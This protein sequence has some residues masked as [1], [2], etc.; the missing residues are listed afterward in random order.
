MKRNDP[1]ITM[2]QN[3]WKFLMPYTEQDVIEARYEFAGRKIETTEMV[4]LI[5]N[6]LCVT[7]YGKSGIGKTSLLQA[8]VFPVLRCMGFCPMV[9]RFKK[10][11]DASKTIINEIGNHCEVV[12]T[13][14]PSEDVCDDDSLS[15]FFRS[16]TFEIDGN[17][18]IPVIVF[19]QFEEFLSASYEESNKL[20]LEINNLVSDLSS[21]IWEANYR[22][23]ISIREDYLYLLEDVL[24][25]NDFS[26]L[27]ANRIRLGS[28]KPEGI[29]E[30]FNCG[31]GINN[32]KLRDRIIELSSR[33]GR[34][35][36]Y[37]LS[38]M[39]GM[40]YAKTNGEPDID[41]NT[42]KVTGESLIGEYYNMCCKYIS[43]SAREYIENNLQERGERQSVKLSKVRK[44]IREKDLSRLTGKLDD[45]AAKLLNVIRIGDEEYAEFIHD[46]LSQAVFEQRKNRRKRSLKVWV[47]LLVI[48]VSLLSFGIY[49]VDYNSSESQSNVISL[50]KFLNPYVLKGNY[51]NIKDTVSGKAEKLNNRDLVFELS[52]GNYNSIENC[53]NLR[54][55]TIIDDPDYES[56]NNDRKVSIDISK[57]PLLRDIYIEDSL[58]NFSLYLDDAKGFCNI[59]L[60]KNV[61]NFYIKE[62]SNS[63]IN[64]E[65]DKEDGYVL[66]D[67]NLW[68]INKNKLLFVSSY[69]GSGSVDSLRFPSGFVGDSAEYNGSFYK[70]C[71]NNSKHSSRQSSSDKLQNEDSFVY[72]HTAFSI[73]SDP[74]GTLR[75]LSLPSDSVMYLPLHLIGV[76]GTNFIFEGIQLHD[77]LDEWKRIKEIHIPFADPIV[78]DN[79]YGFRFERNVVIRRTIE[80]DDARP[81]KFDIPDSIKMHITLCVP[82]GSKEYYYKIPDYK[83][84]REIREDS[85]FAKIFDSGLWVLKE[86]FGFVLNDNALLW[87]ADF[88]LV[89]VFLCF[90]SLYRDRYKSENPDAGTLKVACLSLI[91]GFTMVVLA[92]V[93][94]IG[95]YWW[96]WKLS[97]GNLWL[98][99]IGAG[100]IALMALIFVYKG[101]FSIYIYRFGDF[102]RKIFRKLTKRLS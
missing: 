36:T 100:L 58:S 40:I 65:F 11:M 89:G 2:G 55:L 8:G 4:S 29:E 81:Y 62:R 93:V 59:H 68:N 10:G 99:N 101:V 27:K 30:I 69:E 63:F 35:E 77:N 41:D 38:L 88:L 1:N 78:C 22:F 14:D 32:R 85:E 18:V 91:N 92:I 50:S 28:L 74:A 102:V 98:S 5:E 57:A 7:L 17:R 52:R 19:D 24:D 25:N 60:G 87:I 3:P 34:V 71:K 9:C 12:R 75:V 70:R 67:E 56:N 79:L 31:V 44:N 26:S 94:F 23:V 49:I 51:A 33:N 80:R 86:S 45:G 73:Y 37:L 96:I 46:R 6:N 43:P 90:I 13:V 53:D 20:L 83:A 64:F 47:P 97:N 84:F 42:A 15:A 95:T 72:R 76:N 48:A 21:S 66:L 39:C 82:A 61:E 16:H 54:T